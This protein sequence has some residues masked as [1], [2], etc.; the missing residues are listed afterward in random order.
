MYLVDANILID[1]KNRYYAF[2]IAPGFWAWLDQAHRNEQVISIDAV[3]D[4]LLAGHDELADWAKAR[5]DFF[6]PADQLTVQNF[7]PLST[8]AA[9]QNY[10]PA[11][12]QEF[13]RDQADFALIAHAAGHGDIVVTNE[14]P[15]PD[16]RKKV[17]IPD[18]CAAM[19]VRTADI[20]TVLRMTGGVLQLRDEAERGGVAGPVAPTI[21]GLD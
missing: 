17:K 18:A 12:L 5:R 9:S 8:W 15:R 14:Q 10:K 21:P 16:S 13:T 2:D 19:G 6:L 7:A 20:F 3:R 1:A 4:E 11:A